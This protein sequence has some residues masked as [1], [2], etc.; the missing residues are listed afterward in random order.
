M[1]HQYYIETPIGKLH[2]SSTMNL[3]R[4]LTE[5]HCV[6]ERGRNTDHQF[7]FIEMNNID[8]F[9]KLIKDYNWVSLTVEPTHNGPFLFIELSQDIYSSPCFKIFENSPV[10]DQSLGD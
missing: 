3:H 1:S 4:D 6:L 10:S 7:R 2:F 5:T 9:N 8:H